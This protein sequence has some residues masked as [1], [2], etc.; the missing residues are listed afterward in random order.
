MVAI[1]I[2]FVGADDAHDSLCARGVGIAHRGSE[3]R[4]GRLLRGSRRFRIDYFRGFDSLGQEANSTVDLAQ[5]SLAVLVVSVFTAIAIARSPRHYLHHSRALP[6]EQ[7]LALLFQA[8]E[9]AGSDVVFAVDRRGL[10][11]L[12]SSGKALSHPAAVLW[13]ELSYARLAMHA[14]CGLTLF[15][16]SYRQQSGASQLPISRSVISRS[17][18]S[19]S[20][21]A[22]Y[23]YEEETAGNDGVRGEGSR[24]LA[25]MHAI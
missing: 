16:Q 3:E 15:S 7:K 6:G 10:L 18:I 2:D 17:V 13:L 11:H 14:N 5:T 12:R 9:A 24:P 22:I 25:A 21:S 19:R 1:E 8:F 20:V 4:S 23:G